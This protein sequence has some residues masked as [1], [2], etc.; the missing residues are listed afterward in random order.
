RMILETQFHYGVAVVVPQ[1]AEGG[2]PVKGYALEALDTPR[3]QGD[4]A[5]E[6]Q[7]ETAHEELL[8]AAGT[9]DQPHVHRPD[10]SRRRGREIVIEAMGIIVGGA[11]GQDAE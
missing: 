7:A 9:L 1:A 5:V 2:Q 11:D 4:G 3:F 6:P 10:H 8:P